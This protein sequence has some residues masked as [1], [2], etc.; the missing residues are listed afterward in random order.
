MGST[1][2]VLWSNYLYHCLIRMKRYKPMEICEG[3]EMSLKKYW[4]EIQEKILIFFKYNEKS[5][6]WHEVVLIRLKAWF[7]FRLNSIVCLFLTPV[8]PNLTFCFATIKYDFNEIIY[9]GCSESLEFK[10][11][12][13]SRFSE[14]VDKFQCLKTV[15]VCCLRC[16]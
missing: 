11:S 7:S 6:G 15:R 2:V 12:T 9:T 3:C 8:G 16:K 14:G 13:T 4:H 1:I 5:K 10:A